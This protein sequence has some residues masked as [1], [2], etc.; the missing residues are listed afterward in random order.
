MHNVAI[1]L[2]ED[3]MK[4][5]GLWPRLHHCAIAQVHQLAMTSSFC[6]EAPG[7]NVEAH[8]AADGE[9]VWTLM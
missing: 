8:V 7:V 5:G 3:I 1:D 2:Q 4:C 6:Y 9:L